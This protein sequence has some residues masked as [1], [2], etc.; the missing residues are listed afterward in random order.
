MHRYLLVTF[1]VEHY[2]QIA[3]RITDTPTLDGIDGLI[4]E[5]MDVKA[6]LHPEPENEP[7]KK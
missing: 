7:E 5:M 1:K 2:R 3:A 6:A 4:K